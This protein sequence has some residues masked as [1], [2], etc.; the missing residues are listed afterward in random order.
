MRLVWWLLLLSGGCDSATTGASPDLRPAVVL[1]LAG[2]DLVGRSGEGGP[3]GGFTTHPAECLPGLTC[4]P[5]HLPDLPGTC[6]KP[7]A[8]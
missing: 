2:V 4:V 8:M 7:D 3:C 5:N 6:E 1:D